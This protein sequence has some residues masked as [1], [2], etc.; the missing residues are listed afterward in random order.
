MNFIK[1]ILAVLGLIFGVMLVFWVLG[2]VFSMVWYL[3]WIGILGGIAYGGW[4]LFRKLE[5]KTLGTG[6]AGEIDGIRDI[7]MSWD[8]YQRKYLRK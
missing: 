1:F 4:K 6:N 7:H 2:F 3:L 5:D 8:E